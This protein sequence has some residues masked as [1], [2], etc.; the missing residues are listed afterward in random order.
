MCVCV[1]DTGERE[2]AVHGG[3]KE[4]RLRVRMCRIYLTIVVL[5]YG[6]VRSTF[7]HQ[8]QWG[9]GFNKHLFVFAV[10]CVCC[11]CRRVLLRQHKAQMKR[12]SRQIQEAL[13]LTCKLV[14]DCDSNAY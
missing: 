6:L 3:T 13:V 2:A 12:K 10:C 9:D 14:F 5:L 8:L 7:L 11:S 4:S 1:C